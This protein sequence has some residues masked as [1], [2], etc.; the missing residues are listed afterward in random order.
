[1]NMQIKPTVK[2]LFNLFMQNPSASR[3]V[4]AGDHSVDVHFEECTRENI[5]LFITA[6]DRKHG[7]EWSCTY[8]IADR[9]TAQVNWWEGDSGSINAP[10]GVYVELS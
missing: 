6:A 4:I 8:S 7:A 10:H 9:V 1:M 5:T 3:A 2:Q